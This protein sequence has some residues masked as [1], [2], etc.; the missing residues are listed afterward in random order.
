[1]PE[2]YL[3]DLAYIHDV[4]YGG[5]AR[6]SAP[7]LLAMFRQSGINSGLIVDLGCGSGLWARELCDAGYEVLGVDQSSALLKIARKRVPE[8]RFQ[9]GSFLEAKL[10]P[11]D[12]VTALGEIFN[13]LFDE[14]N[15]Q[16]NL[17]ELFTRVYQVLRPGGVFIFDIAEPGRGG[18]KGKRQKNSQGEDWAILLETE[19][20]EV[21]SLLTRRITSFRRV[22]K[23]Y[24]RSEEIHVLNLFRGKVVAEWLRKV[25]FRVRLLRSYGDFRF[26]KCWVGVQARKR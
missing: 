20:D 1:M 3:E 26:P 4:G 7:G 15:S 11:C 21:R 19:E 16:E 25:G 12:G 6:Q 24:R 8:A 10:A 5:F 22:G 13:Y 17:K 2:G 23:W 18:G 14:K 9:H